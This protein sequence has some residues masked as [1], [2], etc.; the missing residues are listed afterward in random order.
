MA[1]HQSGHLAHAQGIYEEILAIQPDNAEAL[2]LLGII[3]YQTQNHQRAVEL[4]DQAIAKYPENAACYSNRGLALHGLKQFTAAI[5]S[6]DQAT[7]ICPEYAEAWYNRGIALQE[8]E[9]YEAAAASYDKAIELKPDYAEA[10]CTRGV[11][12]LK[13]K[14]YDDA[15]TSFDRAISIR[16]GYAEAWSSRGNAL[17]FLKKHDAALYSYEKA[18][19]LKPDYAEAW[20]N[21]GNALQEINQYEAAKLSYEKAIEI[22]PDYAQA[23]FNRGI[24][25]SE[26]KDLEAASRSYEK[27][28][29]LDP[30]I[31]FLLG[32]YLNI[33]MMI[34][35]WT[36]FDDLTNQAMKRISKNEKV[37]TPGQVV[38]VIG[39]PAIIKQAS[40]TYVEAKYPT[41][42][43]LQ[44]IVKR[45]RRDKIRVGYY[46]ADYHSHATMLLM[47]ELFE[48]HDRSMFEIIAFSFGP[49]HEG[50]DLRK[51]V[52]SAFDQFIDVRIKTDH[53]V[54]GLSRELEIDIAVDLKGFTKESR[55]DIFSFRA[56]P[57]QVNYLGYPGTM[58]AGYMDYIIADP[59]LIPEQ[60]QQ[61]YTEKI[62]YLPDSY[63]VN[64]AKRQIADKV[65]T[66]QELG[67]P[68]AGFVFCCFN[69]NYKITPG[70]F[71]CWMRILKR[72]EGSVLW[73]FDDNPMVSVN[74][75]REAVRRGIE[76]DRLV[77][78]GRKS[79]PEHLARHRSADLFLDT[80]PYNAHTTASDALWSGLPVLT[81][82]GESFAGR[83][84]ASLLNAVDLPELITSTEE[85]YEALAIELAVNPGK[86][87]EIRLKL[88][89]NRLA[90][91]LFDIELYTRHIESAYQ[92][93]YN[94]YQ[95]DL[96]PDHIYVKSGDALKKI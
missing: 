1:L 88:D 75:R 51:R 59:T 94:R 17:I 42:C 34:C 6:Y 8:I 64:D 60:S 92:K 43:N 86:L 74:L 29:S 89:R 25:L 12:M 62:V 93:M 9:Q 37:I 40:L 30:S 24:M 7:A 2:H 21:R 79:L 5:A 10:F 96:L 56:A 23:W 53:E 3:A 48:K 80:L 87:D 68:T 52:V 36:S 82:I 50:D 83:V 26:L 84:A 67:L 33:I 22:N 46:S 65:F 70:T 81:L 15:V 76:A 58:G 90:A 13:L 78:A 16:E 32:T 27:A 77:F 45:Q 19:E 4:I 14:M 39:N 55:T 44:D 47:A 11:V 31:E 71:D 18:I 91:P 57:I 41:R 61:F 49:D 73:L 69:N 95:L 85:E 38:A 63:Q 20:T 28:L 35:D 54:A 66:R 72:V